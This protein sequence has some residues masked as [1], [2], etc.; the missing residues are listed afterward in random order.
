MTEYKIL[1]EYKN[2]LVTL[3]D[4]LGNG[5]TD[6]TQLQSVGMFLFNSRTN[7]PFIGVYS[8]DKMPLLKNNQMCNNKYW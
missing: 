7:K 6:N 4:V 5:S 1:K 3:Q 2:N 8:A